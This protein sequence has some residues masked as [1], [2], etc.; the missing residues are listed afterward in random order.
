MDIRRAFFEA[1]GRQPR[2]S[3]E[4]TVQLAER[5]YSRLEQCREALEADGLFVEG[6]RGALA[7]H[8][9]AK[10]EQTLMGSLR[11]TLA[12][13]GLTPADRKVVAGARHENADMFEGEG[14]D[15]MMELI[16]ERA[17]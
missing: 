17:S 4:P 16:R 3:E 8:P 12:K 2:P 1:Y 6:Q 13:L 7:Q 5:E 9:A 14:Q 10:M 11:R 15:P